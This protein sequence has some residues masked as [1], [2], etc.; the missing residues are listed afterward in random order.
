MGLARG[1]I[2]IIAT[3]VVWAAPAPAPAQDAGPDRMEMKK[4]AEDVYFMENSRGSSNAVFVVTSDGVLLFDADIRSADQV[5][6]AIRKVTDRKVRYIVT[7]HASGDHATGMWTYREDKP[8]YIATRKQ[9]RDLYM[10]E[11][12][13]F[14]QRKASTQQQYAPYKNAELVLPD[15]AFEGAMTLRF[16]GLTFQITE[17]GS[18]HSTSDV[19]LYIPQRRLFLMGDLLDTEIH[20]GQGESAG[21]FFS[22]VKNWIGVLDNIMARKLPVDTYVPGHGPVHVGRGVADLEEQK[23]YFVTLRDE[24]SKMIAS[25]KSVEQVQAEFK[26][27]AEFAHYK[28][29]PRLKAFLNLFYHQ[30]VEQGF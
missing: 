15:I 29:P 21:V 28:R 7:S 26:L 6:A 12:V 23:K 20:P 30:L 22:N 16:G 2:G 14:S 13:E 19:T 9:M 24:V 25:G 4:I 5:L 10:Q 3:A 18:A 11:A 1:F 8:T 17:E 27:P